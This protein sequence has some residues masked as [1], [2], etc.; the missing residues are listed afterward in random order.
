MVQGD[1]NMYLT[2]NNIKYAI[3]LDDNL[4]VDGRLCKI[5]GSIQCG[6]DLFILVYH[7]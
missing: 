4:T 6:T 1:W 2:Y 3:V 7:L 5:W